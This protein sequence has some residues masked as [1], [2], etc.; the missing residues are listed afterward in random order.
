MVDS[1]SEADAALPL[2]LDLDFGQ[3]VRLRQGVDPSA[4][5][6]SWGQAMALP[7]YLGGGHVHSCGVAA[8]ARVVVEGRTHLQWLQAPVESQEAVAYP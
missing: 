3:F 2:A 4:V 1:D 8:M 6:V 5:G 7:L